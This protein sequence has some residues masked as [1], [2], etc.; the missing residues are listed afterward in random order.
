MLAQG[1]DPVGKACSDL[2]YTARKHRA[3]TSGTTIHIEHDG[4]GMRADMALHIGLCPPQ[5]LFLGSEQDHPHRVARLVSNSLQQAHSLE[6]IGHP[7]GIVQRPRAR[8]PAIQMGT[9]HNNRSIGVTAFEVRHDIPH[10]LQVCRFLDLDCHG[11]F[12]RLSCRH[13][14]PD[15]AEMFDRGIGKRKARA[16]VHAPALCG[17]RT[18]INAQI[19]AATTMRPFTAGQDHTRHGLGFQ[20]RL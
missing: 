7:C 2:T 10:R 16:A 20:K 15:A 4:V 14:S 18:V 13:Q 8:S 6:N 3:C 5:P 1:L 17:K 11:Q 9:G 12:N 19:A